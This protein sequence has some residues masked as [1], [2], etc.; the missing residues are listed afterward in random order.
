MVSRRTR[1]SRLPR[2][3]RSLVAVVT[4]GIVCLVAGCSDAADED[5]AIR[6][7]M[8]KSVPALGVWVAQVQGY[9]EDHEVAVET[10]E[11][12]TTVAAQVPSLLG[13]Q[14]DIAQM[15]PPDLI[16]SA[17]GGIDVVTVSAGYLNQPGDD[18]VLIVA[19]KESGISSAQDLVGKRIAAP[20]L[21]GNVNIASMY[22][23]A[24]EGV[25]PK[26]VE[27]VAAGVPNMPD[28]LDAGQVDAAEGVIPFGG[29]M[30]SQGVEVAAPVDALGDRV[31]MSFWASDRAWAEANSPAIERFRAALDDASQWI[32]E[33]PDDAVDLLL[34]NTDVPDEYEQ[35]IKIPEFS[36]EITAEDLEVWNNAMNTVTGFTT[37]IPMEQLVAGN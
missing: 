11:I 8:T 4:L 3:A 9:F 34:A 37:D 23:L 10:E 19:S 27:V 29:L 24:S 15:T 35:F 18:G 16:Q 28:L 36:T 6:I 7:A 14:Y 21:N 25:D 5:E 1:V 31:Q 13:R 20:S 26:D 17:E 2:A 33:N 30:A 22:W 12:S 32:Q